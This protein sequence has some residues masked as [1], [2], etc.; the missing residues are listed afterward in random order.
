MHN[1]ELLN[2]NALAARNSLINS[3][4]DRHKLWLQTAGRDGE[5][6]HPIRENLTGIDFRNKVIRGA[7][8][9][10]CN[11]DFAN[12]SELDDSDF[13]GFFTIFERCSFRYT[14]FSNTSAKRAVFNN[15]KF[16][17]T[18]FSKSIFGEGA[19]IRK[20]EMEAEEFSTDA[21]FNEADLRDTELR[22]FG[23]GKWITGFLR[24]K[25][26]NTTFIDIDFR[27]TNFQ[28]SK[29]L[30]GCYFRDCRLKQ[31]VF[32]LTA[33]KDVTF[34]D[35]DLTNTNFWQANWP[36]V[37]FKG[38]STLYKAN[39]ADAILNGAKFLGVS[40]KEIGF[41]NTQLQN[42]V[43]RLSDFESGLFTNTDLKDAD[44]SGAVFTASNVD[45]GP[46]SVEQTNFSG[47]VWVNGEQCLSGSF[48][49]CRLA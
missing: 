30:H 24:A 22:G 6:F 19:A 23:G 48:G 41:Y 11:L 36:G 20:T 43:M 46:K 32:S 13:S 3:R 44:M 2:R 29:T 15:C 42:S 39:F 8:F 28:L 37:T 33:G 21:N 47:A 16:D 10:Q 17:N 4:L 40:A 35:S 1:I 9:E 7:E 26:N 18:D 31:C 27:G 34:E 12:F 25:F 14:D 5:K 45:S 38:Q 49:E